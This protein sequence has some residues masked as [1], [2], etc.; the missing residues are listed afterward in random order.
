MNK[1]H[2][3]NTQILKTTILLFFGFMNISALAENNEHKNALDNKCFNSYTIIEKA[4]SLKQKKNIV[5]KV[6]DY[7]RDSNKQNPDK[8]IDFGFIPGPHF[9]STTG[10][11]LGTLS[12]ATYKSDLSDANI[13]RSNASLY[14]DM[15]TGGFFSIGINGNHIFPHERYRL[16]YKIKLSTF[17]T[18]FWGIGYTEGDNDSNETEYRRN[19]VYAM[20]RFMFKLAP[21][22][23]FGPLINY[24]FV[25]AKNIDPQ[26]LY[27]WHGERTTFNSYSAGI[28]FTYDSRDFILNAKRGIFFQL[29]QT[30]TPRF[31]G[32]GNHNFSS[33]EAILAGYTPIW[34]GAI[35]AA[36]LHGKFNY[37]H[38][39]WGLLSEIGTNDRM[40]GYY[41]G[42]YRDK[43][44]V[45]GQVELRQHIKGRHG[46]VAWVGLAN[47]FP[48]FDKIAW[49]KTLPNVGIGYRWEF[50]K[51]INIRIDYGLTK[52]G[53]GFIFNIN[54]AF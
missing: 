49:R 44:L 45:E 7:F 13:P 39:P 30:F 21:N 32:N 3:L 35:L 47:V 17:T 50:K 10:L 40:R 27:L 11:G 54:E 48:N 14:T 23:Y 6:L 43:N 46:A 34:Q 41:E 51:G 8:R 12:T 52:N 5:Y 1:K 15:T 28:S 42:R 38:T 19:K 53:S 29:D 9:S 31:M 24:N 25:Q 26:Y 33:T 36:E 2:Y 20:A 37:G 4:D 18:N 16:D 22:T